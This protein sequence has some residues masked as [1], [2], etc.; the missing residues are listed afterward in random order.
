MSYGFIAQHKQEFEV[1][2]MC[3]ALA[4]SVISVLNNSNNTLGFN[5]VSVLPGQGSGH[6]RSATTCSYEDGFDDSQAQRWV[7][8]PSGSSSGR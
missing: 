5:S 6:L 3:Q 2:V 8:Y 7:R 1:Q 4:S